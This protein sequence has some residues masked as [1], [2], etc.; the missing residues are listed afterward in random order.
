MGYRI[1]YEMNGVRMTRRKNKKK[2][3][4]GILLPFALFMS[5][6]IGAHM[7]P[8]ARQEIREFLIPGKADVTTAAAECFVTELK[9]GSS[10]SD[11]I[12]VFCREVI[13]ADA[14]A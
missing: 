8:R 2:K 13:A 10:I 1:D 4:W 7:H 3:P 5:V 12:A 6:L 14:Q 9:Q 11:A